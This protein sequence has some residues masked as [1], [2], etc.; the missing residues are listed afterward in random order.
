MNGCFLRPLFGLFHSIPCNQGF[1]SKPFAHYPRPG[2]RVYGHTRH[3]T[4]HRRQIASLA[5]DRKHLGTD[6]PEGRSSKPIRHGNTSISPLPP[7]SVLLR[8]DCPEKGQAYGTKAEQ[9]TA[10]LVFGKLV[11]VQTFG[12]DKCGRT[13]GDVVLLEGTN[14]NQKL[15]KDGECR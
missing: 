2:Y 7:T 1:K 10:D 5:L 9:M 8:V 15:V 3:N 4:A 6:N 14:V 13:L 11:T 12:H